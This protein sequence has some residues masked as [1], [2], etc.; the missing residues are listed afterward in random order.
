MSIRLLLVDDHQIVREGL[1]SLLA[2]EM[3]IEVV[4]EADNGRDA[5]R[6]CAAFKPDV[7]VMDV[8]MQGLNGIDATRELTTDHPD[9]RV[10]ALSMHSD[11]RYVS[12]MLASGA[13]G[14]LLKDSAYDEL[15][16]GVRTVSNG[17]SYLSKAVSD[18]VVEDYLARVSSRLGQA[19]SPSTR[20]LSSREREVLQLVAEGLSTKQTAAMLHVSVKT[21]EAHRRQIMD[22]LRTYNVAGLVKYAI[23]EGL[24]PLEE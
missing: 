20:V 14:Y 13:S 24:V 17:R 10:I 8:T 7:V 18:V 11:R 23:R 15:A 1:R 19:G 6:L 2:K 9:V 16:T 4:G 12:D 5:L 22:K 3:D 21:V